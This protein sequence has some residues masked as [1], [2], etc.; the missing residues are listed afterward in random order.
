[1]AAKKKEAPA[2][3]IQITIPYTPRPLQREFHN[4]A[5]RWNVAVCH[6]RFGKTCMALN[7]AELSRGTSGGSRPR[8]Y[9]HPNIWLRAARYEKRLG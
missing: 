9:Y 7:D 4:N 6:R 8:R 5:K 1:M 3:E 2:K